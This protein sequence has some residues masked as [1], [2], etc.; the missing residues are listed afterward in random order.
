MYAIRSYYAYTR[1]FAYHPNDFETNNF[2]TLV[3]HELDPDLDL[4]DAVGVITLPTLIYV[5]KELHIVGS[6]PGYPGE[7]Q[8]APFNHANQFFYRSFCFA[9][10]SALLRE[11]EF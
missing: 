6:Y 3:G 9:H 7:A 5:N 1:Y 11:L 10:F 8:F 4:F 2:D